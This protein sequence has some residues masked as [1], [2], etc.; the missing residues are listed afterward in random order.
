MRCPMTSLC[1]MKRGSNY[2]F[3]FPLACPIAVGIVL[4]SRVRAEIYI[5]F[6]LLHLMAPILDFQHTQRSESIR[7][8]DQL[9]SSRV[10][11]PRK[12]G[13]SR[14][15]FVAIRYTT[16]NIRAKYILPVH[17][18]HF[19]FQLQ[20]S[21][22]VITCYQQLVCCLHKYKIAQCIVYHG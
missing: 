20:L 11:W 5:S 19:E 21:S 16:K 17:G 15:N 4:L 12:H 10:G 13:Y 22:A 7:T 1:S 2:I 3:S 9:W 18:R 6:Y 14:W 8:I